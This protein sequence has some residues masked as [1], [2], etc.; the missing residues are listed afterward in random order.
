MRRNKPTSNYFRRTLQR[1]ITDAITGVDCA[2]LFKLNETKPANVAPE[3]SQESYPPAKAL[4]SKI[5]PLW[6]VTSF[7]PFSHLAC[8]SPSPSIRSPVDRRRSPVDAVADDQRSLPTRFVAFVVASTPMIIKTEGVQTSRVELEPGGVR[9]ELDCQILSSISSSS[10]TRLR[11]RVES[12]V[13][14]ISYANPA[15]VP[16]APAP[17]LGSTR[18]RSRARPR[19]CL[20]PLPPSRGQ[21]RFR[22]RS[23]PLLQTR[24]NTLD[25]SQRADQ[26][27]VRA[28]ARLA[29]E[30]IHEL[31]AVTTGCSVTASNHDNLTR[32]LAAVALSLQPSRAIETLL[33]PPTSPLRSKI[34]TLLRHQSKVEDLA[35]SFVNPSSSA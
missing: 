3:T 5:E 4:F 27:S 9:V 8:R 10:S 24:R 34:S 12:L 26:P 28:R 21:P 13:E 31:P 29:F 16:P 32:G 22:A 14:R 25:P 7:L 30:E 19:F 23:R 20:I 6:H 2:G 17:G 33:R 1:K 11:K 18:S 35:N 15:S